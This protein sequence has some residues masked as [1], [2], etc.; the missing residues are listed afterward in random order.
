MVGEERQDGMKKKLVLLICIVVAVF[1]VIIG[2]SSYNSKRKLLGTAEPQT[3]QKGEANTDQVRVISEESD[4][5]STGKIDGAGLILALKND[6]QEPFILKVPATYQNEAVSSFEGITSSPYVLEIDIPDGVRC[7]EISDCANLQK[8]HYGYIGSDEIYE[9]DD[10]S[11]RIGAHPSY[12][13]LMNCPELS[14]VTFS[15]DEAYVTLEA[16]I[17]LPALKIVKLPEKLLGM[18]ACFMDGSGISRAEL[19]ESLLSIESCFLNAPSLTYVYCNEQL[20]TISFSFVACRSLQYVVIP[21]KTTEIN[22]SFAQCP[23]LTLVVEEGSLAEDYARE[24]EIPFIYIDEFDSSVVE[25]L[26][27]IPED[28]AESE[29]A[30]QLTGI[31]SDKEIAD[32]IHISSEE[33][34]AEVKGNFGKDYNLVLQYIGKV[35]EPFV[36]EIPDTY[37]G[38]PVDAFFEILDN[39]YV[40]KI[41][42]PETVESCG[43]FSDCRNLRSVTYGK[44]PGSINE[45]PMLTEVDCSRCTSSEAPG[46][47]NCPKLEYLEL[48]DTM[49]NLGGLTN[50]GVKS[51]TFPEG[52]Q[53]IWFCVM[54]CPNLEEVVI[55]D[56]VTFIEYSFVDCSNL[57]KVYIPANVT[58]I[59]GGSFSGCPKL[60][61]VVERYSIAESY[62]QANDIP[63]SY[64]E[65]GE[66]NN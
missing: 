38:Q 7:S 23:G 54:D 62:A 58:Y 63:Y 20:E 4:F 6:I 33:Y 11:V 28:V 61:L 3:V 47:T 57:K 5:I 55:P 59:G 14:E 39:P 30:E 17:Q 64:M 10:G 45:C 37:N 19:P 66:D 15:E 42:F 32:A 27:E 50:C 60:E 8:L 16:W 2:I 22:Q 31:Y 25:T 13:T 48:S 49:E 35:D 51:L 12:G 46:L 26:Q 40:C 65:D 36:L 44:K 52:L 9:E 56:N 18:T 1:V 53:Q 43:M 34:F 41:I 24:N 29:A 21:S